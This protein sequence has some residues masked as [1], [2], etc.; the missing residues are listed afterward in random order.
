M[1]LGS[2]LQF[3]IGNFAVHSIILGKQRC[4]NQKE[5]LKYQISCS[6][7]F[8]KQILLLPQKTQEAGLLS[9]AIGCCF[10][11]EC[12]AKTRNLRRSK[13][14]PA[15]A[16]VINFRGQDPIEQATAM[17]LRIVTEAWFVTFFEKCAKIMQ[18]SQFS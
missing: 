8:G 16:I 17:I 15:K 13:E 12:H 1:D 14:P 4:I 3:A 10:L 6:F 11:F 9:N 18:F 5:A 2:V 7:E